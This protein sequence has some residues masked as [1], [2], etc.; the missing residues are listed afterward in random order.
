MLKYKFFGVVQ[1]DFQKTPTIRPY[2]INVHSNI[3][4]VF[5]YINIDILYFHV[6]ILIFHILTTNFRYMN[7]NLAVHRLFSPKALSPS[8]PSEN[9][10]RIYKIN[11][12]LQSNINSVFLYLKFEFSIVHRL[13]SPSALPSSS[14]SLSF[15]SRLWCYRMCYRNGSGST[16]KLVARLEQFSNC[17]TRR[18]RRF[19]IF[20]EINRL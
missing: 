8:L 3:N 10:F 9:L 17:F 15:A 6:S 18:L 13:P 1:F 20:W 12:M 19:C 2:K 4:I 5:S 11:V 16:V 14:V 7:P